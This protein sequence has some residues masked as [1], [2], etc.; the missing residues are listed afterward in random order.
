MIQL[1]VN[2]K[3]IDISEGIDIPLTFSQADAKNP[4]KRKRNFSKTIKI[5][6]TRKN[7]LFFQ[8]AYNL[9][10]SDVYGDLIGFDFDPTLRYPAR[11]LR[12]GKPIFKGSAQ[13]VKAVTRSDVTNGRQNEFHIN[14]FSEIVDFVSGVRRY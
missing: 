4:E 6:G 9:H 10:I 7:N 3:E 2:N 11:V 8:S 5:P 12:N 1:F 13:L 14:L